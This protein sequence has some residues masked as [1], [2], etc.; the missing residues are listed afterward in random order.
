MCLRILTSTGRG[1][2]VDVSKVSLDDILYLYDRCP[3]EYIDEP[4]EDVIAAYR[5]AE[6]QR[7]FYA[8]QKDEE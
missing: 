8:T 6:L 7:V 1:G 3:A 2:Y 5:K 4:R